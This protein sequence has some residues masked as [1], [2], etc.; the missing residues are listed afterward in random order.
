MSEPRF[1]PLTDRYD[2]GIPP[3]EALARFHDVLRQRRSIRAF[4]GRPVSREVIEGLVRCATT[5][6]SG[7]NKQPWRFVCVSK[8]ETKHAIRLDMDYG[9]NHTYLVAEYRYSGINSFGGT[10]GFDFSARTLS[11]GLGFAF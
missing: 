2:P 5:A 1:V 6:P 3:E 4:S 10:E 8:A 7:A 11:G 9:I